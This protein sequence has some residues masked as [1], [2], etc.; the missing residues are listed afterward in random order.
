MNQVEVKRRQIQL[1]SMSLG[2][3]I[4]WILGKSIGDN[5][6]AYL[7]AALEGF[8]F[9]WVIIGGNVADTLGKILRSRNGKGQYKNAAK[10]RSSIMVFQGILGLV[11]SGLF[12]VLAQVFSENILRVP[13]SKFIMMILA[14]VI[15]LRAIG[16]VLLG[17]FQGEGSELPTALTGIL[18]Q[19][20]V[21]GFG[22]VFGKMLVSYGGKVSDLLGQEAFTSM[23]GAMGVAIAVL[24]TEV[25]L[26]LFLFVIYRGSSKNRRK[27]DSE[28]GMKTTDS[29]GGQVFSLYGS[30]G[31]AI[32][33]SLLLF[34]PLWLGIIFYQ[35]SV[36]DIY[37]SA[38]H[39]GIYIGK[40]LVICGGLSLILMAVVLPVAARTVSVLRKED[41]R[42]GRN[43]FQS[44][45]KTTWASSLYFAVFCAVMSKQ[46][47][48][49]ISANNVDELA[50][51]LAAGSAIILFGVTAY[52]CHVILKHTGK[53]FWVL[54]A[55]AVA[56]MVFAIV[57]AVCLKKAGIMTLVYG[58]LVWSG[59]LAIGLCVLTCMRL[60]TGIDWLRTV[61]IPVGSACALGLLQFMLGKAFTPH[62][63]NLVTLIVIFVLSWLL[64]WV[65]VL[66]L[67]CFDEQ[68]IQLIPGGK[69]LHSLGQLL[70]VF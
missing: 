64:Y 59:I 40:Y 39:Y 45:L 69:V 35:K 70:G 38:Y 28:G 5:G 20:L 10:M 6:V 60:R 57:L 51:M 7:M 52:F 24:I 2:L 4:I 41:A 68:E 23:Y 53:R 54:G 31:A 32:L 13:Y 14:P 25:L 48:G 18:R 1:I 56:D 12:L 17:I 33:F 58:G 29:F 37:A 65:A 36:A 27:K 21:L 11:G 47:A 9:L 43:I 62:L 46:L 16:A 34:L 50:G 22:L 61:A 26:L 66:F 19:L 63:G 8:A 67:R 15:F 49:V 30:M 42:Q 55:F 3:V 44:G